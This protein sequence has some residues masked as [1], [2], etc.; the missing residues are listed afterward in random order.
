M[1]CRYANVQMLFMFRCKS[2]QSKNADMIMIK[3]FAYL[4]I[5]ISAH[6]INS[7]REFTLRFLLSAFRRSLQTAGLP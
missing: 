5:F 2:T 3:S 4:H 7:R 1:M 6:R